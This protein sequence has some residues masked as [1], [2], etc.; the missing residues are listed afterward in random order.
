MS[1]SIVVTQDKPPAVKTTTS[2]SL[3]ERICSAFAGGVL[4]TCFSK[5]HLLSTFS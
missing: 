3:T 4:T 2:E 1:D 5:K